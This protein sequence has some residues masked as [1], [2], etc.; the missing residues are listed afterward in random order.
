MEPPSTG[1]QTPSRALARSSEATSS[2][3]G[4]AN[5]GPSQPAFVIAD[6][7][8]AREVAA[9]FGPM[10]DHDGPYAAEIIFQERAPAVPDRPA[11]EVYGPISLWRDGNE[12]SLDSGGPLRAHATPSRVVLGGAL[13]GGQLGAMLLRRIVHHVIAHVLSLSAGRPW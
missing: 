13:D 5:C 8:L 10:P 1:S 3:R 6:S 12:L 7:A 2:G 9:M 11:D 4:L